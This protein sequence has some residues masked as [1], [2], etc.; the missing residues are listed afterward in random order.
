MLRQFTRWLDRAI[1]YLTATTLLVMLT[2]VI[3]GV[4]TR[5][6]G[7]PLIWTDEASRYL[8]IWVA[9]LGWVLATRRRSHIRITFII[10]A[11]PA[12][13]RRAME[14]VIQACV[15][16]FG[17][18]MGW[19]AISLVERN[20]DLEA[21]SIPISIAWIYAP[22]V[23]TGAWVAARAVAELIEAWSGHTLSPPPVEAIE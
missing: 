13:A 21:T 6:L 19:H 5:A 1:N 14:I 8:L 2:V 16:L 22:L 20:Y 7:N 3:L 9:C 23:L 15:A 11:L 4:V 18:L 10:D 12:G 17:V